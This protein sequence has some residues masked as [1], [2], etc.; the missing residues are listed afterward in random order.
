M[1]IGDGTNT[2]KQKIDYCHSELKTIIILPVFVPT[3]LQWVV[4]YEQSNMVKLS[5]YKFT[6][7]FI[8][9]YNLGQWWP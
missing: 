3:Y 1:V 8:I 4:I 2:G 9:F 7:G 6:K 5:K